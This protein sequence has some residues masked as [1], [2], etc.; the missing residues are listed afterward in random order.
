MMKKLKQLG[1]LMWKN[2]M[3]QKRRP[4]GTLVQIGLPFFMSLIYLALRLFLIDATH[5]DAITWKE[6]NISSPP[7]TLQQSFS[8]GY[9]TSNGSDLSQ[10][11]LGNL[12]Y[13]LNKN[14]NPDQTIN[15]TH[16][17]SQSAMV[18]RILDTSDHNSSKFI[19][20]IYFSTP[21]DDETSAFAYTLRFTAES[22]KK[23]Q[24]TKNG[25]EWLTKY[26]FP[27]FQFPQPR[28]KDSAVGDNPSYYEAGFLFTQYAVDRAIVSQFGSEP[29]TVYMQRFPFPSYVQDAFILI[30]EQFMPNFFVIAFIYTALVIVRSIVYEKEKRLKVSMPHCTL[31]TTK[32]HTI[33]YHITP[34][35]SHH[36]IPH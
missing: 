30:I 11:F 9:A 4:V 14:A 28:D 5:Y 36:M 16:F 6:Y 19:G 29:A 3:L 20:G 13:Y 2:F 33:L 35:I 18:S 22:S 7:Y 8:I 27:K 32:H 12:T 34:T 23:N 1:L 17:A 21:P 26:V 24:F 31:H 15:L 25:H 10:N